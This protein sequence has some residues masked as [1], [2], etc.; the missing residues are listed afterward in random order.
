MNKPNRSEVESETD[1]TDLNFFDFV[2][3]ETTSK[4]LNLRPNNDEEGAPLG[5]D[6]SLHQPGSDN[7]DQFGS[8][9]QGHQPAH[10]IVIHQSGHD[11]T[12]FENY[13]FVSNLNKSYEPSFYEEASKDINRINAMNNKMQA[14]YENDTW[15]LVDLP[16]GKGIDYDETFSP[17]VKMSIVSDDVSLYLLVVDDLVITGNS[18]YEIEKFKSFLNKKFKIKDLGELKYFLGIK[19]LKPKSGLCLNQRKYCL[20]LL[21]EFGLLACR[22]VVTPLP[23]NIILAHKET[24]DD[25]YLLN[26]TSYQ[27]LVEKL[28]YLCMTRPDISYA[29][30]C[31]SQHMHAPLQSHFNTGLRLLRYLKLAPGYG[32]DFSKGNTG[33]NVIVYSDSDWAKCPLT[34]RSVWYCVFVNESPVSWKSKKQATL[35][36]SS[37][38]AEYRAMG[39]QLLVKLCGLLRF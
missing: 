24:D 28:I 3:F 10:D 37:T 9:E 18:E 12:R 22:H 5:R 20:E 38:E 8:D 26:L 4:A 36:K 30:H 29:V 14:L 32:I 39:L 35:S 27:K 11:E 19:V 21:H 15:E 25:K 2:E 16:I 34:R 7:D 33:F 6:G 31:R 17:V 13:L 23:E 1:V